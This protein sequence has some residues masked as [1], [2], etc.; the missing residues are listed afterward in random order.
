MR[1]FLLSLILALTLPIMPMR[2]NTEALI[3]KASQAVVLLYSQDSGGGMKMHCTATAFEKSA[4]GYLFVS[5]AHCIGND[6]TLKEKAA[7]GK[8]I[9]FF[10]TFDETAQ[11]KKFHPA[12]VKWVGYQHRG[13]DLAVFEVETKE[14]WHTIPL[15]DEKKLKDGASIIN[16][17]SP[18]G[19]GKQVFAGYITSLF[20]DRPIVQGNINWRGAMFL[21]INVGGGSSGSALISDK[22]EAIVGFLVGTVGG[23]NVVGIPVSRFKA[24]MSAVAEDKYKWYSPDDAMVNPDGSLVE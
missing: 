4:K 16:I 3:D 19:L 15:G 9:P 11:V 6:D 14:K 18:L 5:A 10:I 8:N 1:P 13:E 23:S 7:T 20:I 2:A 24:V 12:K 17:A 21:D 22:Q